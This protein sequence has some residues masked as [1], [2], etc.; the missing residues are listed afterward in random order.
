MPE[1][2]KANMKV[3]ELKEIAKQK[4]VKV[5]KLKKSDIIRAIQEAEG[6][7]A[8][9]DIGKAAECGQLNCLWRE[10]CE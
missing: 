4:V 5:G 10:D 6:N 9:F 1:K 8:C 7:S 2:E 3:Q